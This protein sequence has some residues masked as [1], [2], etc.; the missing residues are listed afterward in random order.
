MRL[1]SELAGTY[2]KNRFNKTYRG[3]SSIRV[4]LSDVCHFSFLMQGTKKVINQ[5]KESINTIPLIGSFFR[6]IKFVLEVKLQFE[7]CWKAKLPAELGSI[8]NQEGKNCHWS[9]RNA[10]TSKK[11][12]WVKSHYKNCV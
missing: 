6:A 10:S 8:P 3:T 7:F 1:G 4:E 11:F 9:R 12:Q 5:M 2:D